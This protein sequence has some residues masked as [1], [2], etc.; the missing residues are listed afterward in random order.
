MLENHLDVDTKVNLNRAI[1]EKTR[2]ETASNQVN[3][4]LGYNNLNSVLKNVDDE[5]CVQYINIQTK[6]KY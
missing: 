5:R 3:A 1:T 4:V 6:Y 2:P